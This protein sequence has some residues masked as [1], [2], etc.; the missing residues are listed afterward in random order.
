MN[1]TYIFRGNPDTDTVTVIPD[2]CCID[3][4]IFVPVCKYGQMI[5]VSFIKDKLHFTRQCTVFLIVFQN[6]M[7]EIDLDF[8]M[9]L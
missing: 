4:N 6:D 1:N 5:M 2:I 8:F 3:E 7:T 9:I